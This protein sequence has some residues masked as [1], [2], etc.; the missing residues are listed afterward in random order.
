MNQRLSLETEDSTG[1]QHL[2]ED[3]LCLQWSTHYGENGGGYGY[4]RFSLPRD[5]GHDY[6]DIGYGYR[7]I[8]RK[9]LGTIL[10]DGQIRQIDE[11]SG[12]DEDSINITALGWSIVAE[13]DETLRAFCDMRLNLWRT[14]QELP[15]VPEAYIPGFRVMQDP[16]PPGS[17]V[18]IGGLLYRPDLFSAN[19]GAVGL[20]LHP[21][22]NANITAGDYTIM[23][24]EFFP[25]ETA[26]RFKCEL[27]MLLG[28]GVVFNGEVQS[29]SGVRVYYKNGV[30]DGSVGAGMS[31]YNLTQGKNIAITGTDMFL[32]YIRVE[33]EAAIEDWEEDD[34]LYVPGPLF[35][36]QINDITGNVITY[37]DPIGEHNLNTAWPI[38]NLTKR[39]M[40]T[41]LAYNTAID[42][43]TVTD[44]NDIRSWEAG[45]F[46]VIGTS[47]WYAEINGAPAGAVITYDTDLGTPVVSSDTD[48]VLVNMSKSPVEYATV[49]GWD[50]TSNQVTVSDAADIAG[51]ANNEALR[52]FTPL[53]FS[54]YDSGGNIIW[55]TSDPREG[56]I[57]R[58]RTAINVTKTGDGAT[59]NFTIRATVFVSG[60]FGETSF[61][62]LDEVRAYSVQDDVTTEMLAQY[63]VGLLSA[64]GHD[65]DN[66]EDDIE[67]IT[68][69]IEPMVF[70]LT[71]P[72]EAMTWAC[73]FGDGGGSRVAWG[74]RLDERIRF[75]LETQVLNRVDYVIRRT[76]P[77]E[78]TLG[79]DIM[80]SWQQVRAIFDNVLGERQ[81]TD[82]ISDSDAYFTDH[83]RRKSLRLDTVNDPDEAESL[84]RQWLSENKEAKQSARYTAHDGSVFTKY[85]APIPIEEVQALGGLVMIE[86]W[87]SVEAGISATDLRNTWAV[88]QIVG[89]EIDYDAGTAHLIPASAKSSFEQYMSEIARIRAKGE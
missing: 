40:A 14:P 47:M 16:L 56:A 70:E 85:G 79:G 35:G 43:I 44:A 15:A 24:Y 38:S 61:I 19:A 41:I 83:Y 9:Y 77:I 20:F 89:V 30:G 66:S 18:P 3:Y 10:F 13:D 42:T 71:T 88:E 69:I 37:T 86:D 28:T 32:D 59:P 45:D 72:K 23:E 52:I 64:S 50:T 29:V 76:A 33:S 36:A 6:L 87:R 17:G 84:A 57:P 48:W 80:E 78:I 5:I 58:N 65:W 81:Y 7:I 21:N 82:W 75:Y 46:I 25:G 55:P 53:A 74:I 73:Q 62:N 51:W 67:S 68:K 63:V 49:S 11:G 34:V 12:P 2:I 39:S 8:L 60:A 1:L 27:S 22:T 31:L 26:E 54:V 4:L